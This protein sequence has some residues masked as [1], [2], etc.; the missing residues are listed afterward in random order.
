[1]VVNNNNDETQEKVINNRKQSNVE[2]RTDSSGTIIKKG[3]KRHK[4][5][6]ADQVKKKPIAEV[7][8]VESYKKYN[9]DESAQTVTHCCYIL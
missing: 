7:Y 1:M 8:Y 6:F 2:K 9:S 5:S 3:S 4:V